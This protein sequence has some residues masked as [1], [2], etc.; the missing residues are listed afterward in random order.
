[1]TRSIKQMKNERNKGIL[2]P[3]RA[4]CGFQINYFYP[5]M[6]R[7]LP[8]PLTPKIRQWDLKGSRQLNIMVQSPNGCSFKSTQG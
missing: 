1:M 2:T 7:A 3:T 5:F 6:Y 4:A 8:Q